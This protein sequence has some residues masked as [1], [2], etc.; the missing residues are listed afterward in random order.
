MATILVKDAAGANQTAALVTT[1]GAATSANSFPVVVASDQAALPVTSD[2]RPSAVGAASVQ[3]LVAAAS[4]NSTLVK[5]SAGR[6]LG[7][8]LANTS[9][10]WRYVKLHNQATAPTAGTGVVATIPIPPG[11][12]V[13]LSLEGGIAFATG[14]ALTTTTG[15]ASADAAAVA[16]GDVVGTLFFA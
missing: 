8:Q 15:S 13:A 10:A 2:Y 14:I 3:L 1:T 11:G 5:A 9:A 4:T 7:W 6:L 12:Q 16:A